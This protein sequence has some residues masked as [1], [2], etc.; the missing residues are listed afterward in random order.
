VD[1]FLKELDEDDRVSVVAFDVEARQKLAMT[2]V[3]DV[4]RKAVRASL[5]SEG[6]V[7]ATDFEVALAAAAKQL[8]GVAPDDAMILYV[9]DGVITAG[10][11]QLDALRAKI[12]GKAHFIG[13]G[14]GDGPDTQTLG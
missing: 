6:G 8:D 10:A 14:V 5:K 12:A 3:R 13:V 4:D 2:R 11:R 1:A 9:G 7:G